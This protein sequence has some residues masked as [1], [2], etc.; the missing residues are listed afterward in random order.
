MTNLFTVFSFIHVSFFF[1]IYLLIVVYADTL[2][3]SLKRQNV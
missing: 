3:H 1:Y 2:K